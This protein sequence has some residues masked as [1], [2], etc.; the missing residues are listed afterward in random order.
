MNAS[1]IAP[2]RIQTARPLVEPDR[3]ET[4]VQPEIA[5]TIAE[6]PVKRSVVADQEPRPTLARPTSGAAGLFQGWGP[7]LG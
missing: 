1:T 7:R 3:P 6:V 2:P 5:S 4:T